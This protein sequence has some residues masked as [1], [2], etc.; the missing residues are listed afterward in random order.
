MTKPAAT[1]KLRL[2]VYLSEADYSAL[3]ATAQREGTTMNALATEGLRQRLRE[4]P[5]MPPMKA[6]A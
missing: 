3:R 1:P 4:T 2:M 5:P 6:A